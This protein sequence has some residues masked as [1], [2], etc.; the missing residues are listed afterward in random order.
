MTY[1]LIRGRRGNSVS[2]RENTRGSSDGGL[3]AGAD[4]IHE[5]TNLGV[6]FLAGRSFGSAAHVHAIG[7]KQTDCLGNVFGIEAAGD[8]QPGVH[9]KT[10]KKLR[11]HTPVE[12]P[13][14]PT[15]L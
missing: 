6:I 12:R 10:R 4:G 5:G 8:D 9:T 7:T 1:E 15:A 13:H 11:G 2:K 14:R 3:L